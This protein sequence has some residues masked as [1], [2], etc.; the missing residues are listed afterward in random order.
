MIARESIELNVFDTDYSLKFPER[1]PAHLDEF[2]H[3]L[4]PGPMAAGLP[5]HVQP[6]GRQEWVLVVSSLR[7]G[8]VPDEELAVLAMPRTDTFC[9]ASRSSP[10]LKKSLRRHRFLRLRRK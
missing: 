7:E 3:M 10:E 1:A 6:Q 2:T 8:G 5:I 4:P 9:V